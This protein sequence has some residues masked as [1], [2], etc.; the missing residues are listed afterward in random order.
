MKSVNLFFYFLLMP[1][2]LFSQ[3][4]NINIENIDIVR[5][6]WGVPHVF[7]KTDAEVAYGFG[8]V[9]AE[10]DFKTMQTMLLPLRGLAGEVL[11]KDGAALDVMAHLVEAKRVVDEK[12]EKDI[13]DSFKTYLDAYATAINK[14]AELHPEEVLHKKLFPLDSKDI[15][16]GFVLGLSLM[17]H[18]HKEI[19]KL[20]ENKVEPISFPQPQGSNGFAISKK[21]TTDGKTYLA[22][23]SHQPLEGPYSWYEAHLH[24]EE[25]LNFMGA[26]FVGS[27]VLTIGTNE[28]LGW[29]HTLSYADFSDVYQLEMHPENKMQYKF[30]GK[31]ETLEK[32]DKK[33]KVKLMGFLKIGIKKKFFKSKYG[34][35]FKT[36][37]GFFSLRFT[38][39]KD[40]RAAE[41]WYEM[42]KSS[43]LKEF[44]KALDMQGLNSMNIVYG[45]KEDHIYYL[46][47]GFFPKRNPDYDWLGVVPG[48]TSET[49]WE[50]DYY[51]Q[52][53]LAQSLDP[54]C[55]YVYNC[56]HTPF[57]CTDEK[58]N[59]DYE[60]IPKTMGYQPPQNLT[61]RA[62]RF[63]ELINQYDKINYEDFKR[64]KYDRAYS[65]PIQ[66]YP[67]LEKIFQFDPNINS[68]ISTAINLLKKWDR[69][70]TVDSKA[71]AVFILS[72]RYLKKKIRN[73]NDWRNGDAINKAIL[74][75]AILYAQN[76]MQ[77]HFN[78]PFVTLGELQRHS[79]AKV[80]LPVSGGPD[81]LAALGAKKMENGQL[82]AASGDSYIGLVR[83]SADGVEI[84][85]INAYGASS[86]ENS[87]HFTD[88]MEMYVNRELKKMTLNKEEVYK[89][90]KRIYHPK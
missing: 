65:N 59:P 77:K 14:Y 74:K 20:L 6:Q 69:V 3:S 1:F 24:S 52:N 84:E 55:G 38:S 89:N 34:I 4:L 46:S 85:T 72:I 15:V 19:I 25:G 54:A 62:V 70:A 23:N 90:A 63:Y 33:L 10:D 31:W 66:S 51:P 76:Y 28:N 49:L 78:K 43:N 83:Y 22:L 27:P 36:D 18:V 12:Y 75:E 64:I 30:D 39:N 86:K 73:T 44:K 80:D 61:N 68:E 9:Q 5:D 13:S 35:T 88:Q 11:G 8:W 41:Q 37:K 40:I 79:R 29:G 60:S 71:A 42:G 45:D 26:N 2:F 82:R 7:G 16:Q 57:L 47:N 50:E 58:E 87:P 56:N 48:N 32:F 67:N 81:V 53:R 21:R 17:S